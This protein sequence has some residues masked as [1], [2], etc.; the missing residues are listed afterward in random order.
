[1]RLIVKLVLLALTFVLFLI[2]QCLA[3]TSQDAYITRDGTK[4]TFGSASVEMSIALRDGMLVT[5]GLKNRANGH[6]LS[7]SDSTGPWILVDAKTSKLKQGELQLDLTLRRESLAITRTYVVYPGSSVIREWTEFKNLGSVPL[8]LTD[9]EFLDTSVRLGDP[10]SLDFDWMTGG[11]NAHGSWVLKTERLS[12][13]R[14]RH[15]D[16]DDPF[17]DAGVCGDFVDG[18]PNVV[19]LL[20]DTPIWP[21]SGQPVAQDAKRAVP[22]EV[23]AQVRTGDRVLSLA[24]PN[25]AFDTL[26]FDPTITYGDGEAHIASKEFSS[27]QGKN[28]WRYRFSEQGKYNDLI[29]DISNNEWHVKQG[30]MLGPFVAAGA[31]RGG[32]TGNSARIWTASKAGT[33]RISGSVCSVSLSTST[34]AKVGFRAGSSSYA[35]WVA[36]YNHSSRDGLLIGW[37]YFGHWASSYTLDGRGGVRARMNVQGYDRDLMP[38]ETV[39]TPKAFVGLFAGDLDDAGNALLDWQYRYLWDYTRDGWFPGIRMLGDWWKGTA[40]GLPG[41]SWTGGGGDF[42]STAR[43]VFRLA[44]TMR[45]VGA[46]V[47]HR[48]WG[49]WDRAGDWNGPD[50]RTM[51]EYLRK[52]G[53]GQLIYAFLY[54]VDPESRVAREHPDWIVKDGSG[55]ST[56]NTLDMS[57]PEVVAFMQGQLDAFVAQW[58]DF[59]WRNDS[60]ITSRKNGDD[61]VLL[62][63][64]QGMRA[65]LKGFLDKHPGTAFQAVNGGGLYAGYDYVRYSSNIQFSD[66]AV[67]LVRNYW[68]ALLLPPD[69]VADNPDAWRD[70]NNYDK[71]TWRGWLCLNPDTVGDTWDPVK[72]DGLRELFGI[73]HY[74]Q[75]KGVVGQWVHVFRPIVTGDDPTM[76]FQRMSRDGLRGIIIPKRVAPAPVIIRPKGLLAAETYVVNYQESREIERRTGADLMAKGITLE[77]MPPGELI[78]LNLPMHPGSTLDK[79]PPKSPPTVTKRRADN[80]GFPGVELEWQ[81]GS[82]NNWIFYYEIFRD[83]LALDKIA[84]GT[85]YFDHSAGADLGATYEVRTVDGAGNVSPRVAAQGLAVRRSRIFD[86]ASAAGI[87]FSPQW[88]H[89]KE[90]PLVAYNGTITSSDVKGATAEL[91]FEGKRVLWFTRLGA[92]NGEASVSIDGGPAQIVDTYSADDI[93]GVGFRHEFPVPGRHTIRIEVLGKRGV[94][95]AERSTGTLIFVDGIRVEME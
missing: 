91:T 7:P 13:D 40:W 18:K 62:G 51:G 64:D 46:D 41:G 69:K 16:S 90:E 56:T 73:Y 26:E 70:V 32:L 66:A 54:T 80:M 60:M 92:E 63:Q 33:V 17:P 12:V 65:V 39:T 9:P 19:I 37:D 44:D 76:Y 50:F 14:P 79:E 78:Y 22:I 10:G 83:G 72:L 68:I 2:P 85:F 77:K 71:A 67:G 31:Q 58:G 34:D 52:S 8:K 11:N 84:K 15:F 1:M 23:S 43:K 27:Q 75:T 88:E 24:K 48:D 29:A 89:R 4:W 74:L 25:R 82:D 81:P 42:D 57:R 93:W 3:E 94:H 20:N 61:T 30:D 87:Q 95:P 36:L 59:E 28:G 55:W 53:M 35:P 5:T 38:G 49:W 47:Y 21:A 86:D 45:E 6:D